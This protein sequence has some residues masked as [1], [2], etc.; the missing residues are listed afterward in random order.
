MNTHSAFTAQYAPQDIE[1][2]WRNLWHQHQAFN[3]SSQGATVTRDNGTF[4]V[5]I[6]PP[7][8]T[9]TLHMGHAFQHT[10]IDIIVRR[11][12][13]LGKRTLWQMGT[14]HAGIATQMLV[15]R[16]LLAEGKDP[17]SLGREAFIDEVQRWVEHS[18]SIIGNQ[19]SRLGTSVD[20]EHSRFTMDDDYQKAV[21]HAFVTLYRQGLIYRGKR[22]VNW[23]PQL[24][25]AISDLEVINK[26]EQGVLY[27]VAYQLV[28]G[29]GSIHIATTR[30]E[31]ILAD[32]AVAISPGD[33]RYTHL[34]GKMVWVPLTKRQIPVIEDEYVDKEFGTGCV[35]ITPAHDFN[36]YQV[37]QRHQMEVI[38]LFTPEAIMNDNA[39][40][41]YRGLDRFSARERIVAD[42]QAAGQLVKQQDHIYKRPYGDRSGVV[43][44]PYFTDQWFV[45]TQ[46]MARKA[47]DLVDQGAIEFIPSQWKKVY[48][49]WM[50]GI[51]DWCISRQ[52][53]WGHR[54]PAWYDEQGNYY[55]GTSETE[56]RSFH[57][58]CPST[59][60]TQDDDVL[61]TWFSS[62]L[63]TFATLGWPHASERLEAF[64]PTS[65]MVTGFDIIFFWVARM[66]ML[67]D[68]FMGQV[69]FQQVYIHGLVRDKDGQKMSKSKGNIIDPLHLVDGIDLEALVA[70]RTN[71]LMQPEAAKKIERET[72]AEFPNGIQAY[73]V[74]ALRMTFCSLASPGRDIRFDLGRLQ[75]Y[76]NFCN[77]LWNATRFVLMQTADY[78]HDQSYSYGL[79]ERW[80]VSRLQRVE[81]AV[82]NS[83]DEYRFDLLCQHLYEF[84][85]HTYCDWYLEL[86]KTLLVDNPSPTHK[87]GVQ[88]ALLLVLD[89]T[90]RMLHPVVP[91][92]SEEL[93]EQIKGRIGKADQTCLALQPWPQSQPD[94]IDVDAERSCDWIVQLVQSLRSLRGNY[95]LA[96]KT[97]IQV[98]LYPQRQRDWYQ[99]LLSEHG[100]L[101]VNL[102]RLESISFAEHAPSQPCILSLVDGVQVFVPMQGVVD[103]QQEHQR[104]M[105]EHE[106]LNKE[107]CRLE[108]KLASSFSQRAPEAIVQTERNK[109][110][111][112]R[113]DIAH[114]Q[115]SLAL[116]G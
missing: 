84:T 61:D 44:E 77:K 40:P 67:T 7:N 89:A 37:G 114:T 86:A 39:P 26:E 13:M 76:R 21:T 53:W 20:W 107:I 41:A 83:I 68:H 45:S 62:G 11:Q 101:I 104:L 2:K 71:H 73:G 94:R 19:I 82:H 47:R 36:D 51:E 80:L 56:A 90:L 96:P 4:S 55:I 48:F 14:D 113:Q 1:L 108:T 102:A 43:I 72:R 105:H 59:V 50:D 46:N 109:L 24:K 75:G 57:G 3:P 88:R 58:L 9:G 81:A 78:D 22:L 38:N 103:E 33:T 60:L 30:P 49:N 27:T 10:L 63:W 34:V 32:G 31:T 52:L 98:L 29:D 87:R 42:L 110:D 17:H 92:V 8:V 23:D 99:Q 79:T 95:Q 5:A 12:R 106:R 97:T 74:D 16:K 100:E 25:T 66:I 70:S 6:P 91:F 35:K 65:V 112:Y 85:W 15:T 115:A 54:I 18:G 28:E 93:W 116:F 111:A 64:H 69:P